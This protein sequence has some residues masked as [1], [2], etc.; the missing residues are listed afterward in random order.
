[1]AEGNW[2]HAP[3]EFPPPVDPVKEFI[4]RELDG[5]DERIDVGVAIVGG[6]TAGLA[7][8]NRLLQLL[9]EDP[10]V[11]KLLR[12]RTSA[13]TC[14]RAHCCL[15][16]VGVEHAAGLTGPA[17]HD[18]PVPSGTAEGD[19]KRRARHAA[20]RPRGLTGWAQAAT[21]FEEESARGAGRRGPVRWERVPAG[22][23]RGDVARDRGTH[24]PG[25]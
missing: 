11:A 5:E 17:R 2:P 10:Q 8:A 14:G 23:C 19:A 25:V 18:Q 4:K 20:S 21:G 1:M 7:C 16:S 22:Y 15:L 13:R 3:G 12:S 9:G 24:A 6:G